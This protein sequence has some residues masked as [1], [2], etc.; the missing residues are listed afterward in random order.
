MVIVL[1]MVIT[2]SV[3]IVHVI[4]RSSHRRTLV[5]DLTRVRA[6]GLILSKDT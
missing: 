6:N 2:K 3:S 5:V 1:V 4:I